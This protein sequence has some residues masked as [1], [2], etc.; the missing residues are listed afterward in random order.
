MPQ[1]IPLIG[2]TGGV[3]LNWPAP[4]LYYCYIRSQDAQ[5]RPESDCAANVTPQPI[6]TSMQLMNIPQ[7]M[8]LIGHTELSLL[9]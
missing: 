4:V 2:H 7:A 1:A 8:P 6:V 5:I 3:Q 9:N